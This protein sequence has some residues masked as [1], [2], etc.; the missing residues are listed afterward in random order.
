[1]WSIEINECLSNCQ[2]LRF[3]LISD[4]HRRGPN[5]CPMIPIQLASYSSAWF[6]QIVSIDDNNNFIKEKHQQILTILLFSYINYGDR[7]Q[8]NQFLVQSPIKKVRVKENNRCVL[9]FNVRRNRTFSLLSR[10]LSKPLW[11]LLPVYIAMLFRSLALCAS[12]CYLCQRMNEMSSH[13]FAAMFWCCS[14]RRCCNVCVRLNLM[15]V[16]FYSVCG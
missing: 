12:V 11:H 6:N 14:I 13:L 15:A 2:V 10:A 8:I 1:M 3:Q 7:F 4:L 16:S 5:H 9:N